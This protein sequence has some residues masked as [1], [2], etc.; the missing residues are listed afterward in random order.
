MRAALL[1]A[2]MLVCWCLL[3]FIVRLTDS[4]I[5]IS[6]LEIFFWNILLCASCLFLLPIHE[7]DRERKSSLSCL[8]STGSRKSL[9]CLI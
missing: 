7:A 6:L 3:A 1:C 5:E 4:S 8:C 2:N 9:Q